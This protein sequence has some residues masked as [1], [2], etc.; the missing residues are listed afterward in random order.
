MRLFKKNKCEQN[1]GNKQCRKPAPHRCGRCLLNLCEGHAKT[2]RF[3]SRQERA[4]HKYCKSCADLMASR[5]ISSGEIGY[6]G[7]PDWLS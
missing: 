6:I 5:A 2:Y 3:H 7:E 4:E 1:V